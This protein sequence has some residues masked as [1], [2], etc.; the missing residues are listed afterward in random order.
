MRKLSFLMVVF[1]LLILLA[2]YNIFNTNNSGKVM[3]IGQQNQNLS[4]SESD[5][6]QSIFDYTKTDIHT[7]FQYCVSHADRVAAGQNVIQDLISTGLVSSYYN[8]ITC[9]DA[10]WLDADA[11]TDQA[12]FG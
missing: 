9:A 2:I 6:R 5:F 4:L 12:I 11:K 3:A 8:N 7:I 1:A 10:K